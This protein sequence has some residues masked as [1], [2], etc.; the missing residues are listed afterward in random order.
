MYR[1]LLTTGVLI[2]SV[3][4]TASA[5]HAQRGVGESVGVARMPVKP[6]IVTFTGQLIAINV[7]PCERT[8]GRGGIGVHLM[9]EPAAPSDNAATAEGADKTAQVEPLNIHVGP[10]AVVQEMLAKFPIG[11]QLT[12]TAFRTDKMPANHYAAQSLKSDGTTVTLR[13]ESLRPVWAGA[14]GR[15][16][17]SGPGAMQGRGPGYGRGYGRQ[18]GYGGPGYGGRQANCP[19]WQMMR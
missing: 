14:G 10:A 3:F 2:L 12:V 5:S 13:D 4:A 16:N 17:G 6:E 1:S 9:I 8:T 19:C 15:G 7:G 18:Y 11:T